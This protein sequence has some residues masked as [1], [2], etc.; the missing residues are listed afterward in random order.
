MVFH[1]VLCQ[2]LHTVLDA[3]NARG[4]PT[5]TLK[6]PVLAR[7][8]YP[9][10]AVRPS[11][12]LDLLIDPS[13]LD[14]AVA[15]LA[16]LGFALEG[17]EVGRFFRDHHHH[18]HM[19]HPTLPP[20]EL[21]FEA[22]LGF[23]TVLPAAP[24]IA[25][26]VPCSIPEWTDARVLSP[27]DE[28]LYLAVHAASHRFARLVWL[29]DLKLL[30]Q[31]RPGLSW[32]R[33]AARARAFGLSEAVSCA[34]AEL[35]ERL[36]ASSPGFGHLAT[37]GGARSFIARRLTAPRSNHMANAA[38]DFLFRAVLCDDFAR[39]LAFAGRFVRIK[40]LHEAPRRLRSSFAN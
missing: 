17:G 38:V 5:V 3:L 35:T 25:S 7:R 24:L 9:E 33:I 16:P 1:D 26:S 11:T 27:E 22:Y 8:L 15:A 29:L 19:L 34:C 18:V 31:Q 10:E 12:D 39:A 40:L 37:R 23:G 30:L 20:L 36:G 2:T 32:D 21:H 28:L 14:A 6:G 4:I 13:R